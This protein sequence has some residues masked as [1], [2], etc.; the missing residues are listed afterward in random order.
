MKKCS[1]LAR[2]YKKSNRI[3]APHE[4]TDEDVYYQ[5]YANRTRLTQ[6]YG[7]I[8]LAGFTREKNVNQM[9]T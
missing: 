4:R 1:R 3:F 9:I 5:N 8:Q 2:A 6:F 7:F